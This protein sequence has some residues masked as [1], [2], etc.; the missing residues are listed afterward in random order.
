MKVPFS[1]VVV[2]AS[3]TALLLLLCGGGSAHENPIK[4]FH[5]PKVPLIPLIHNRDAKRFEKFSKMEGATYSEVDPESG[6][7]LAHACGLFRKYGILN[8]VRSKEPRLLSVR[9]LN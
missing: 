5:A 4:L 1:P 9:D 2:I 7:T 3:C 6:H 8:K